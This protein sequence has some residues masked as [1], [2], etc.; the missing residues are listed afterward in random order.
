MVTEAG[1]D[2]SSSW[3]SVATTVD[4]MNDTNQATVAYFRKESLPLGL[5]EGFWVIAW[6]T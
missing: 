5:P 1:V 6:L 2:I 4:I 3:K